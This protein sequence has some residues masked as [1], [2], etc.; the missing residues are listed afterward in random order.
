[1][2][3]VAP[4]LS[5]WLQREWPHAYGKERADSVVESIQNYD[6]MPL[7][8]VAYN[9]GLVP[10]GMTAVV[11][12]TTPTGDPVAL[13]VTLYVEPAF[14]RSGIGVALCRRAV[15]EARRLG[16][17]RI[18]AYTVDKE[19]FFQRLGWQVVMPAIIPSNPPA[20]RHVWYVE[21]PEEND[22]AHSLQACA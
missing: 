12:G 10:C 3:D 6:R 15:A 4:L 16:W 18:G 13:V 20:R 11:E 17:H 5:H 19:E 7:C 21:H 22:H 9:T 1:M 14:R 8:L 2:P